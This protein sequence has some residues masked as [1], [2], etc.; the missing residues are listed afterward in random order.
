M[1]KKSIPWSPV[2]IFLIY[3]DCS[4]NW[5][6][7]RATGKMR[8]LLFDLNKIKKEFLSFVLMYLNLT[9]SKPVIFFQIQ[10]PRN[11]DYRLDCQM[12]SWSSKE[13]FWLYFH[14]VLVQ[15]KP[16]YFICITSSTLE[17][18]SK[19]Q[20]GHNDIIQKLYDTNHIN[21]SWC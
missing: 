1:R 3:F 8:W 18:N 16:S 10:K 4:E 17:K 21:S 19:A 14:P 13:S 15:K 11:S 7:T 12:D 6:G 9:N 5:D 2:L 20:I